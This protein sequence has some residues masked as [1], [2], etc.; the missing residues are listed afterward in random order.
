MSKEVLIA[1]DS[2]CDLPESYLKEHNIKIIYYSINLDGKS[3]LD[4]KDIN[5]KELF[6]KISEVKQAPKTSAIAPSRYIEFFEKYAS[7]YDIVFLGLGSGFSSAVGSAVLA[8]KEFDNVY[9][10]DTQNLSAG[11]GLLINKAVKFR[12]QGMSAKDIYEE[13]TK[14]IPL[15]RTQFVINTLKYLHMGGRCSGTSR[16]IGSTLRLKPIIRVM[17]NKMVVSKKPIG[18]H[19]GLNAMLE[20]VEADKGNI[21]EDMMTVTH[22][23]APEDAE[24]LMNK[25]PSIVPHSNLV[26][27]QAGCVISAHCGPRTIG[28]LYI[29]K[30]LEEEEN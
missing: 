4:K 1:A 30:H 25:L 6:E 27:T 29:L 26:E 21:D 13:V 12:S 22:C 18:F 14:L 19:R 2:S 3:Y 20:Y 23:L 9:V 7:D 8:S 16:I 24:Y 28:V 11:V 10:I 5:T 17:N 15:V